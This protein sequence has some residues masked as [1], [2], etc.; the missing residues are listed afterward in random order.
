MWEPLTPGKLLRRLSDIAAYQLPD[1]RVRVAVRSE[2]FNSGGPVL[3][4]N[5]LEYTIGGDGSLRIDVQMDVDR[6]LSHVPRVGIGLVLP[7]RFDQLEWFGRGPG[8]NY[9]DRKGH[10]LVGRYSSTVAQQ[11]FPFIPPSE[12]GG[13]EDVR[14]VTLRSGAGEQIRVESPA[15]FHFDARHSSVADYF[16]AKHDHELA[17]RDLVYLNLDY[18]HTGIGSNMS[19]S[20]QQDDR[21]RVFADCY[22]FRFDLK[23][24]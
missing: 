13:H 17:K 10:T 18:R 9:C 5:E 2:L 23:L 11:H 19:W 15:L 22:R 8:E 16:A 24:T 1:G 21:Y 6:R 4:Y 7:G 12:C 14:W 3:S 20:T